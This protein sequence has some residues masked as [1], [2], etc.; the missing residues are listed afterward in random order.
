VSNNASILVVDDDDEALELVQLLLEQRGHRV[1]CAAN[2]VEA[3]ERARSSP[4]DLIIS[5]ILMPRMDG[6]ALCRE[7]KTDSR[8][9]NVPFVFY[10]ATYTDPADRDLALGLGAVRFVVKPAPPDELMKL[11]D[12]VLSERR[13]EGPPPS[14]PLATDDKGFLESYNRRLVAKLED[15]LQQIDQ[16]NI[17]LRSEI[18]AREAAELAIRHLAYHDPLTGLANRVRILQEIGRSFDASSSRESRFAIL[19]VD[20]D[21]FREFNHAL[22]QTNGD[23]LLRQVAGR[24]VEAAGKESP[25]VARLGGDEFAIVIPGVDGEDDARA[26]ATRILD[27]LEPSFDLGGLPVEVTASAG[28]SLCPDHG[29]DGALLLRHAEVAMCWAKGSRG[30]V[31]VYRTSDDP[32]QPKRLALISGL[33]AGLRANELVLH[34]Q[35]K[36]DLSTGKTVGAEALVRWNHPQQGFLAPA[37][38]ISLAEQ[39]GQIQALSDWLLREAISQYASWQREGINLSLA[40][41]LSPRNLQ[42]EQLADRVEALLDERGI[43]R[44]NLTFEITE[45]AILQDPIR[46]RTNL[47]R[48]ARLGIEVAVDDFGTGYSS[49]S[50]LKLLPV[51][52]LKIDKSFVIEMAHDTNDAAIVRSTIDLAHNLGLKV[53]AEG[54]ETEAVCDRLVGLGCDMA[55]GFFLARPMPAS[56]L[57]HWIRESPWPAAS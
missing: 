9:R 3:L 24:L 16:A 29:Q 17:E 51:H 57:R 47:D 46:A 7:L 34:F 5:D 41:N 45:S 15:K 20:I 32:F 19:V 36:I 28:I 30:I 1:A 56:N 53:T 50:N 40:M 22:G 8:L 35:P 55:Q 14:S 2:G 42:S 31:S 23:L 6:Y 52:E 43:K 25:L 33:R 12:Q 11:V 10:S 27:R 38:F 39:T 54:V 13:L 49:L 26:R 18:A 4:P 48:L 37:L 21:G 44:P